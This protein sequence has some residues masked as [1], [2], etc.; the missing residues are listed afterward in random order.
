[1]RELF[2]S[3]YSNP[4]HAGYFLA[5]LTPLALSLAKR[6][7]LFYGALFSATVFY[8][9]SRGALLAWAIGLAIYFALRYNAIRHLY[10][11]T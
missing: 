4:S 10:H 8:T 9:Q 7:A 6:Y 3:T 5:F 1:M 2:F 11:P